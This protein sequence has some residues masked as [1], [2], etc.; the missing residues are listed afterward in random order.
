MVTLIFDLELSIWNKLI[1]TKID[2]KNVQS[3][4]KLN[5]KYQTGNNLV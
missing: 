5:T 1:I 2:L 4:K 3:N